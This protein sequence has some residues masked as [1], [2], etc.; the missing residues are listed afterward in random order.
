MHKLRRGEYLL[1]ELIDNKANSQNSSKNLGEYNNNSVV[2]R[3]GKYGLY[4]NYNNKNYSVKLINKDINDIELKDVIPVLEGK[5]SLSN[6]NILHQFDETLSIRKGKYGPYI[7]YKAQYMKKPRFLTL[8]GKD[9]K[10]DFADLDEL[11]SWISQ[12]HEV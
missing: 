5:K 9:W 6:P 11:R 1:S 4:V 10:N 3:N 2:L 7:F 12:E 8:K